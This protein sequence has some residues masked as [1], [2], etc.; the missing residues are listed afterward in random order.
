MSISVFFFLLFLFVSPS[1]SAFVAPITKHYV[2]NTP[3][4]TLKVQ[5]KTPLEPT[6]LLLH[7]GATFTAINCRRNYTSAT[8]RP[9]PC[10]SSLC[11]SLQSNRFIG[12]KCDTASGKAAVPGGCVITP[13]RSFA[14]VDSL[15]L[16]ATDGR[17]PGQ[18]HTFSK[19]VFT[20]SDESS[21]LVKGHAK[22]VV[23]GLAGL[24]FS[25]YSLPAQVSTNSSVF[26]LCVSGSPSA[27]GVA[28]FGLSKPYYFL[29]GI[30]VTDYLSYTPFF[31]YHNGITNKKTSK[32]LEDSYFIKVKSVNV[33]GKPIIVHQKLLTTMISTTNPYTVLE[34]SLFRAV[35]N[36]FK[37]ESR[38]MKLKLIKPVKPFR[39]CYEADGLLE[40]HLGPTVPSFEL[41]MQNDIVWRVFGKNSMVR[42]VDEGLDVWC[43]AMVDGGTGSVPALLLGGHQLEDNLLQFN[44]GTKTLGFS[45][46]LLQYK[47]MCANFNFSTN[48]NIKLF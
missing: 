44:L 47:T 43:L 1:F 25:N 13:N 27:P 18:I 16:P 26:A 34:R 31:S 42:I 10:N 38:I 48:N 22:N 9:V 17:N 40:T 30:D 6:F 4:Y 12:N 24:G 2:H 3:F 28:F 36:S 15:A 19:F 21:R 39:L 37:K 45:S 35:F 32:R 14:L 33:N 11:H 23:N 8:S 46:S 20:C 7:V 29:P 41:V 5:L